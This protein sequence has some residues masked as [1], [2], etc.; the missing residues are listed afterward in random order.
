MKGPKEMNNMFFFKD[1]I[2]KQRPHTQL[3]H[4]GAAAHTH[5]GRHTHSHVYIHTHSYSPR[6]F[7]GRWERDL[8]LC[9]PAACVYS[10]SLSLSLSLA[11]SLSLSLSL[12][13]SLYPSI[14]RSLAGPSSKS[15]DTQMKVCLGFACSLLWS[16]RCH[17]EVTDCLSDCCAGWGWLEDIWAIWLPTAWLKPFYP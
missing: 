7:T 3:Y 2:E 15:C 14:S 4:K 5:V 16:N 11:L 8:K 13:T 12:S 10:C 6:M 1:L 17:P 9:S